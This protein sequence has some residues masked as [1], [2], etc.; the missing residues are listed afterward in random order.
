VIKLVP[1]LF[2]I[3]LGIAAPDRSGGQTPWI[4]PPADGLEIRPD[5]AVP[6]VDSLGPEL[7]WGMIEP[8]GNVDAMEELDLTVPSFGI[9][10]SFQSET[11][12]AGPPLCPDCLEAECSGCPSVPGRR[13]DPNCSSCDADHSCRR[14][15]QP[16]LASHWTPW[17]AF[18]QRLPPV[19][20]SALDVGRR[21]RER[22]TRDRGIGYE[23]VMFAPSVLDTAI[24]TPHFGIRY[25]I[26]SGLNVADRSEYYWATDPVGPGGDGRVNTQDVKFRLALGNEKAMA[27]TEYTMRSL[28]PRSAENTTGFGDMMIGA[29]ALLVDG[30]RTKLSTIFR[31][32]L[33]TGPSERGL[34]TGH[35]SLEPGL[36]GRYCHSPETYLFGELKYWIPIGGTPD[37]AGDVLI[38][39]LGI[40]TIAA[41]SDVFAFLPTL[42]MR[43]LSFLFGSET[44][45]GGLNRRVDG[46]TAVE[47]YPGAR[48]VLGPK[49]DTGLWEF[50]VA[51]GITVADDD[52]FDTRVV[53]DLRFAH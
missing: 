11:S 53:L 8:D 27:M 26:D 21:F 24:D 14:C 45:P 35:T 18:H 2:L 48:F 43:T 32:H 4:V 49:G 38:T 1:F 17:A 44:T 20:W 29:R 31:T 30:K 23:R 42:E 6:P 19:N 16:M 39:G 28:D 41:E 34:G 3:L 40:S 25:Q 47:I 36:L 52:W 46:V 10:A 12:S 7:P 37:H 13:P 9:E 22:R 51:A 15:R 33:A 50:G 5:P